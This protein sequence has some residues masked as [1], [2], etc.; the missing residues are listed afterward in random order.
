MREYTTSWLDRHLAEH[1]R[2]VHWVVQRQWL[3]RLC[4]TEAVQAGRVGLW[5]ALQHYDPNRGTAFSTYAVLAIQRTVWQAVAQA[6]PEPYTCV[7]FPTWSSTCD[8]DG[9]NQ[10]AVAE[11]V[12]QRLVREVLH[13]LVRHMPDR[14]AYVVIARY[15]LVGDQPQTWKAIGQTLRVTRQR[16]QQLHDEALLWLAH[17]AHSLRLR[18]LV[19]RNTVADYRAYLARLR[20]WQR[21]NRRQR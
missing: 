12:D 10:P 11:I 5:R 14:L 2:L 16:A 17:P 7:P 13:E 15:G 9:G 19:E 21:A 4:Y 8:Y 1:E 3:G 6:R 18:Q 20:S